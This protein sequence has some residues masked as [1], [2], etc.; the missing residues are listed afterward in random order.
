VLQ[1]VPNLVV[2]IHWQYRNVRVTRRRSPALHRVLAPTL[3]SPVGTPTK[4][5]EEFVVTMEGPADRESKAVPYGGNA[6]RV[7]TCSGK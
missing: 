5:P 3:S 4:V 1:N 7:S 6:P 2:T